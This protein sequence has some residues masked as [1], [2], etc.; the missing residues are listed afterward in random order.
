M[1][2]TKGTFG[3]GT[4]GGLGSF[5][6]GSLGGGTPIGRWMV[7]GWCGCCTCRYFFD[8]FTRT[9]SSDLGNNW[10]EEAGSWAIGD[11]RLETTSSNAFGQCNVEGDDDE[12]VVRASVRGM[13]VGDQ[14][15]LVSSKNLLEDSHW[16]AEVTWLETTATIELFQRTLGS[17]TQR[18]STTTLYNMQP[19]IPLALRI[20]FDS[21]TIAAQYR[22]DTGDIW[23]TATSY[24]ASVTD[25]TC[26]V[27]TGTVNGA[28][29]FDDFSLERHGSVHPGCPTC[30]PKCYACEGGMP[31]E[32]LI[33]PIGDRDALGAVCRR[34]LPE[35]GY[36]LRQLPSSPGAWRGGCVYRYELDPPI[37]VPIWL[38]LP[39]V[40]FRVELWFL[41]PLVPNGNTQVLIKADWHGDA[42]DVVWERAYLS[43]SKLFPVPV[44]CENF[45]AEDN[46]L[47]GAGSQCPAV[48]WEVTAL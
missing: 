11:Y 20:C 25:S 19:G 9:N 17:N 31:D 13:A 46:W 41:A 4:F 39:G 29:R 32:F 28:V 16:F 24:A 15:R 2:T 33:V 7:P 22:R 30:V 26:G 34:L 27:G 44:I 42:G 23:T 35:N 18:G 14:A 10:T 36:V 48:D 40:V 43:S 21:G 1:A 3:L 47:W 38:G 37:P 6:S 5:G 12:H 8:Q 45:A